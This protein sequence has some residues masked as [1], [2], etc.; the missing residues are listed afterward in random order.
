MFSD[1]AIIRL[2]GIFVQRMGGGVANIQTA[3]N[4][5][6]SVADQLLRGPYVRSKYSDVILPFT[7]LR[8]IDSVLAPTRTAVYERHKFVVG[9][10]L[11]N[12]DGALQTVAA[13]SFYNTSSYDFAKLKSDSANIKEN[14]TA[15]INGFSKNIYD[16]LEHFKFASLIEDLGKKGLLFQV[17]ERFADVDLSPAAI[18]NHEMGTIFEELIRRFNEQRN[19]GAGEHFTPRDVIR[20]MVRLM[21]DPPA[22]ERLKH[23][24]AIATIY[25]PACGTGGMLTTAKEYITRQIE[26]AA[27]ISLFGQEINDESYAICKSDL[28]IGGTEEDAE[29]IALGSSFS[30]DAYSSHRF[31][32]MLSNPPYGSD[33]SGGEDYT[34][35]NADKDTADSR[36]VV[37]V[38]RTSDGQ[39][40]FLQ[41]MISKMRPP[42]EGGSRIAIVMNGSPLF[43][44]DAGSGESEI[45][46]WVLENDWLEA[47]VALPGQMFYNTGI[48]TYIWLLTNNKRPERERKVLLVNGAAMTTTSGKETEVFARK[49]RKSLGDKRNEISEQHMADLVQLVES[50]ADGPFS[51]VFDTEAFGYRKITIER[52][53]RRNWQ[54]SDERLARLQQ[55]RA[56]G[57]LNKQ[58]GGQHSL[59]DAQTSLLATLRRLNGERLYKSKPDFTADLDAAIKQVGLK[60]AAPLWKAILETLAEHDQTAEPCY[61]DKGEREPNPDLRDSENVTLREDVNRYFEREVQPY[62]PD[63]WVST[64]Y[65]DL[66]DTKIG[67][68]GYEIGFTRYFYQYKPLR[69]LAEIMEDIRVLEGDINKQLQGLQA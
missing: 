35:I 22:T 30:H 24:Q 45:R 47:I 7:V 6:W 59:N 10:G 19:E 43:V 51:K 1:S 8:R 3:F 20:L 37:G 41:Q 67:K 44:G 28:L 21:I 38:P 29:N 5:I 31:R 2:V 60:L 66:R 40:L 34:Y 39:M 9:G 17:V 4:F 23:E 58:A 62:V 69:P 11:K 52:P 64:T 32:F 36:F 27:I 54:V 16:I 13:H 61:T 65:R 55:H 63:A 25:D 68:V 26:P 33:W 15:Y 50:F 49:L 57:K 48:N 53:M 56:F 46:R 14:L 42:E 18:S 12:I